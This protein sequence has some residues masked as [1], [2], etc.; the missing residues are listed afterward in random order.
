MRIVELCEFGDSSVRC[1][2]LPGVRVLV[3]LYVCV[4]QSDGLVGWVVRAMR[5]LLD[6]WHSN[7]LW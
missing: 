4:I 5:G 1:Q 3:C 6:W 2:W 7:R